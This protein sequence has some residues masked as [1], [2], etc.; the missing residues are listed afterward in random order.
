M[1][2]ETKKQIYVLLWCALGFVAVLVVAALAALLLG[3]GS[4]LQST[5][6]SSMGDTSQTTE[7]GGETTGPQE[8]EP[9]LPS[10]PYGPEDFAYDGNFLTCLSG[11][12]VLG[13]DVSTFQRNIDWQAVKA[14]G[15]E[16]VIIRLGHR[17]TN[18][19]VLF[20]DDMA[21]LHY[22]GAIQAGLKVGGY[23]F[24][25]AI[26]PEEA[27][28][29]A[30]YCLEIIEGWQVE[31]PL[32]FDWEHIDEDCRTVNMDPRTLTDC[33]KAFCQTVEA[34]GYRSMVYFNQ[35]QTMD[36]KLENWPV[37]DRYYLKELT[38]YGFWLAMYESEM[39]YPVKI[40]MWQYSCTGRVPGINGNVDLNIYFPD[41]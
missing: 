32:V 1:K 38:D 12:S 33:A 40:Q 2:T 26:T 13:I 28:E 5:Q 10:N 18:I 23:F 37:D 11:S 9:T 17:G 15:I 35:R 7:A 34:A 22:E 30:Q 31:M 16:F 3:E 19:G 6:P 39:T 14:G 29:E 36:E 21:K 25:Q 27:R 8:T 4:G 24:S 20:E 41:L